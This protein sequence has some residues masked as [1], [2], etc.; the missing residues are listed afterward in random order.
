MRSKLHRDI[1]LLKSYAA[2]SS[3]ALVVVSV[4]AFRQTTPSVTE[5]DEINVQRI[6]IV[7]ADGR[8]RL[9]LSNG[10]R[11]AQVTVDGQQL[12]RDRERPA[13]MIFFN[14]VGDEVG[15]LIFRGAETS[16]GHSALVSLS[17]DRWKQDQTAVLRYSERNGRYWSGLTITD[18]SE[19]P[20]TAIADLLVR[21]DEA[22]SE[23]ERTRLLQE[24]MARQPGTAN[25]MF[26]GRDIDGNAT[27]E[28]MDAEGRNRLVLAVSPDG[29]ARIRFLNQNGDTVREIAP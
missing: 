26:A 25:R 23:T 2:V 13:G 4:A 6:N 24:I 3:L 1:G 14:E 18:R 17:F 7:E 21:L 15:G 20:L 22:R 5:F 27:I 8:T 10:E 19:Q 9:V 12:G 16:D 28:L 11:Q 29:Q